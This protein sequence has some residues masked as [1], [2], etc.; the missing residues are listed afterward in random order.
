MSGQ[1]TE[2]KT[3]L[4]DQLES[5]DWPS[6]VTDLKA[7]SK[8]KPQVAQLL[9]QLNESYENR[10]NY[11]TGTVLN[12]PGYGGGVIARLSEKADKYPDIA[13]FHTIRI[14]EPPGWVYNTKSLRNLADTSSKYGAGILQLHG[15]TGDVLLLGFDNENTYKAAEALMSDGW[16]LG[17]SG[18]ALRTLQ[19][20][21]GQ[22]RCEMACYDTMRTT[23]FLTDHYID[24]LHRP[25]FVYKFKFKLSGCPNDCANAM[26]RCDM[27]IIG[28]W[29]GPMQVDQAEV[30]AFIEKKGVEYVIDNV[31]TRC[32]TRCMS[33]RNGEMVIEHEN[34]VRC[35]HC[36]NVMHKA[37]KP[38]KDRGVTI[39]VGGKRTLKIGDT[40]ST[41]IVPFMKLETEEDYEKLVDFVDRCWEFWNDNGM[42]HER[43]GEFIY[44]VG[45]GTFL[46]G[47]GEKPDARMVT[48]P[49]TSPYIK[50][51][52]LA[53]RR[54]DG[55]EKG[56]ITPV[57]NREPEFTEAAS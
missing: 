35:M 42:D 2:L 31:L 50:F 37:L 3:P 4:L 27:P 49:R 9:N 34:C 25:E 56:R 8:V 24:F 13:Q 26:M 5:G 45:L 15:M 41:M 53:P 57:W 43:I 38:G 1:V 40:M 22:A 18:G 11:W 14:I 47:I 20:C 16:D 23:K 19:C 52:E 46:E 28:T 44:R 51:E 30:K 39:L 33:L 36:I 21:V 55:E 54:L 17:G 10:W 6:F 48:R 7:W 29:R 32:P 12:V